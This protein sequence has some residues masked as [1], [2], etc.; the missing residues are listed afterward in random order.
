[1]FGSIGGL[2]L[3]ALAAIGL[4]VFGP[5]R[6]PEIGRTLGR[7]LFEFK[8]TATDLRTSIEREINLEE[9]KQAGE[10]IR[11]SVQEA[12]PTLPGGEAA[13]FSP[14]V[15]GAPAPTPKEPE[16]GDAVPQG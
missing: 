8:R 16:K 12:I 3:L 11:S 9:L 7:T 14:A 15:P 4:L 6:L 13:R 2:E 10:T 5:R 1:M